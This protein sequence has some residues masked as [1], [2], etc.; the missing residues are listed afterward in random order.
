MGVFDVVG[1]RAMRCPLCGGEVYWQSKD[2]PCTMDTLTVHELMDRAGNATFYNSCVDCKV[3]IEV[4]VRRNIVRTPAQ[5]E[6]HRAEREAIV[7]RQQARRV[8]P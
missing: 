8:A 5:W 3:F 1:C 4:S 7:A 2:G 6:Q